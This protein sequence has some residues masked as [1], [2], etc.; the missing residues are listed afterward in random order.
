[1][2]QEEDQISDLETL[3]SLLSDRERAMTEEGS[4]D[5]QKKRWSDCVSSVLL[6]RKSLRAT[7]DSLT[8]TR[9]PVDEAIINDQFDLRKCVCGNFGAIAILFNPFQS[10]FT[11]HRPC[12]LHKSSISSTLGEGDVK[13]RQV[14]RPLNI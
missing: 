5:E 2:D 6:K 13:L 9:G 10:R 7:R 14:T 1:M 12:R 11:T 8:I 3:E 4:V